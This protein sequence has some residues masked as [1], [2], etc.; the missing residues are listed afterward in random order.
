[1]VLMKISQTTGLKTFYGYTKYSSEALIKEYC[2][3]Y[4]ISYN[5]QVVVAG[6]MAMG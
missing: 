5:Q 1:M 4:N 6:L 2:Y 3:A